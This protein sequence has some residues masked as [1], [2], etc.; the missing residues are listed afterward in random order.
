MD[1]PRNPLVVWPN[2][3]LTQKSEPVTV[4]DRKLTD[5]INYMFVM[6]EKH[7]GIGLAAPQLG[8][9]KRIFVSKI[10]GLRRSFVNPVIISLAG[11]E[12]PVREGC[13]SFPG[14]LVETRRKRTLTMQFQSLSAIQHMETHIGLP[15]I[16]HQHEIDHLDGVTF[17]KYA[18]PVQ[19]LILQKRMGI[20]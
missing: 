15:S 18:G 1:Y 9:S 14:V 20:K 11:E 5:F 4:F 17:L 7:G 10:D 6:M 16:C 13:L 3:I 8:V 12:L 19:R 2:P